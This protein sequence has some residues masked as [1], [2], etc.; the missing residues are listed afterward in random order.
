MGLITARGGSKSVPRKNLAPVAGK[1]LIAWTIEAALQS[2]N[3]NRVI[4]STDDKEI[5]RVA[6]EWGAEVPF[7]R[8]A[9]LA[10]DDSPHA[11]VVLHALHWMMENE[12][13]L[14]KYVVLL[15]PTSPLRAAVDIDGAVNLAEQKNAEAVV[16]VEETNSHPYLTR[17]MTEGEILEEFIPSDIAYLRRQALPKAYRI[18]GAAFLIRP[19][20]LRRER[21]FY[22]KG[23]YGYVMPSERSMEVDTMWDWHLVDL[24]LKDRLAGAAKGQ[25]VGYGNEKPQ[26]Q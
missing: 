15:Q 22:P 20:T 13:W 24:V 1:P 16:A 2:R 18:N 4:V 26:V 19:E 12:R 7:M 10:Q 14:A 5:A 25:G 23:M 9:E 3:L 21:T 8:P 11:D 17:K 6:A